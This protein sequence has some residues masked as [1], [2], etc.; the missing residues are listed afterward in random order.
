MSKLLLLI[1]AIFAVWWLAKGFRSKDAGDASEAAPE[2]MVRCA[3]CGLYLPRSEA[4]RD[5]ES[6]YCSEGHRRAAR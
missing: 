4:V 2:Q 3:H 6:Y 1:L 5:G